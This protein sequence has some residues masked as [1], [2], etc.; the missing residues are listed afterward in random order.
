MRIDVGKLLLLIAIICSILPG[1][2]PE[3]VLWACLTISAYIYRNTIPSIIGKSS[4]RRLLVVVIMFVLLFSLQLRHGLLQSDEKFRLFGLTKCIIAPYIIGISFFS[5]C[6]ERFV[7]KTVAIITALFSIVYMIAIILSRNP[8]AVSYQLGSVNGVTGVDLVVLPAV[9]YSSQDQSNIK[10]SSPFW[11]YSYYTIVTALVILSSS[12]TATIVFALQVIA[13]IMYYFIGE[14][15][16][17]AIKRFLLLLLLVIMALSICIATGN[18]YIDPWELRTR[19]GIWNNSYNQFM[20]GDRFC[21]LFGTGNDIVQMM[22]NRQEAHNVFLEVL[23]IYGIV[24]LV[25][26]TVC[27]YFSTRR[28]IQLSRGESKS[29]YIS[30]VSYIIIISLHP[31]YTGLFLFQILSIT[32]ILYQA[33]CKTHISN[34]Q[35]SLQ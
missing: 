15:M 18:I 33:V 20:A 30:I 24:G 7:L 32:I 2:I 34:R 27:S 14:R 1:I 29:I 23:L 25:I 28:I 4:Y 35:I 21:R 11:R 13:Y 17:K 31:F 16:N 19:V 9:V 12:F 22:A 26:F 3:V 5:I 10:G 8:D 6:K